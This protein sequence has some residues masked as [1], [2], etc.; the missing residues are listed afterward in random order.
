MTRVFDEDLAAGFGTKAIHAGQRPEPLAGAIMT[1]VYLTSTYVQEGVGRHKGY[2]Y[3]R[4]TNPTREAFERNV[5]TLENGR[6]GFAFASG[7]GCLDSIMKLF[8]AGDH[9][10]CAENVYGGTFRLFDKILQHM[11]LSFSYVD[12]RNP[13]RVEDAMTGSTRAVIVETPSNPL[14]RLTDVTAVAEIAHRRDALLVVDNT[15]ASPYFQRPLELG[16]DIVYHSTTKY[17]NGHSDMIGG[18][19]VVRDDDLGERLKFIHNA[20]GAVAGPFD[21]WLALR[22]TKTLHLRMRQHDAN[23]REIARWLVDRVGEENVYYIGLPTHPQYELACRQMSG[24]GGMISV[25]LG[26]RERAAHVL[27]RVR[28]FSLAESLGGVESLI[29]L[30]AA[31]THASVPPERRA[32]MGLSDGLVR[33]SCGVED[34]GDLLADLEQAFVGLPE[35]GQQG[36]PKGRTAAGTR[37]NRDTIGSAAP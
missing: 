31:M 2:E 3:S 12:T 22:G 36:S 7:M 13:E 14:M 25:E 24:F 21:A 4:G 6:H 18:V 32:A 37:T 26:T 23:G 20:A 15:F 16:A 11:G 27:E 10:V 28:V 29:S 35:R 5:A 17:L 34:V 8:R 19:A 1:P 9:F 33:L 30:P